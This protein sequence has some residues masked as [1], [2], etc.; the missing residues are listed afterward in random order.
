MNEDMQ[1]EGQAEKAHGKVQSKYGDAKERIKRSIWFPRRS[2]GGV[3]IFT[4]VP[5]RMQFR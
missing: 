4:L 3:P 2:S 5:A 1:S